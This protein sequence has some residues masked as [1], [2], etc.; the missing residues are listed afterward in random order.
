MPADATLW[1]RAT[2]AGV[3]SR[4]RVAWLGVLCLLGSAACR[5]QAGTGIIVEVAA[6]PEVQARID[7]IRIQVWNADP[8]RAIV[9]ESFPIWDGSVLKLPARLGLRPSDPDH[10][11]TLRIEASGLQ[12]FD[13]QK[14]AVAQ[15]T[16]SFRPSEV[17]RVQ[18]V[19]G[20][21]CAGGCA[22]EQVCLVSGTCAPVGNLPPG[23]D[24]GDPPRSDGGDP[25]GPDAGV[26]PGLDAGASSERPPVGPE[27]GA[28]GGA[29]PEVEPPPPPA[30]PTPEP[31]P[32][33]PEPPPTPPETSPK[34]ALGA[35]CQGHGMCESDACIDGVCCDSRCEGAC[36]ACRGMHTNRDDGVCAP[37]AAGRDPH[38]DCP[39]QAAATCG[40][41]GACDG[42]GAC[43]RHPGGTSCA[44]ATCAASRYTPAASCNGEG[45]CV[46][47]SPI[48]C[49][50]YRCSSSGCLIA[51]AGHDGCSDDA[52]CE[53]GRCLPRKTGG[54]CSVDRECLLGLDCLLGICI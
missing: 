32:P 40:N 2:P 26:P 28:D 53:G 39:G 12:G 27:P 47:P 42:A 38:S 21:Y 4:L 7:T 15:T 31:P 49:S 50:P 37:V 46:P 19:L 17:M 23:S 29:A 54:P 34:L 33:A 35:A 36:L 41:A 43:R 9:E 3:A 24:A 30:P 11:S 8:A 1:A 13:R 20:A 48:E 5:S 51:C 10:T 22:P 16:V 44:P 6:T 45:A 52:Y 14:R 18:L 25:P